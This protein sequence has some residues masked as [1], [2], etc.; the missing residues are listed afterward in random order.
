MNRGLCKPATVEKYRILWT[1]P[2]SSV[3]PAGTGLIRADRTLVSRRIA[4]MEANE[5]QEFSKQLKESAESGGE[6]LTN[7]SLAISILAVLVAMVTVLGHRTHTEA[8]LS[9]SRAGDQ[10]NQYQAKKIR[11]DETALTMDILRLQAN[12]SG[13]G[14]QDKLAQY[15]ARES[16]WK[17][18]LAEEEAHA[19]ELE[20][21][22]DVAE[23]KA[24][25]YDLGEAL[26]QIAVV[27]C[28]ITLFTRRR[29][30]FYLGLSL[31]ALGLLFAASSLLIH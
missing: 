23:H 10:W 21:E 28:S 19:R 26:L 30:Y 3:M 6:S 20:K 18:D 12:P 2:D 1:S 15:A 25:R 17:D 8:V 11:S 7:I 9:Q 31:G 4:P 5:I 16:K 24:S 27:L 22:V 13:A 14:L 29:L